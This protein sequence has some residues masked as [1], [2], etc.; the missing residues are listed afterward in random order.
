MDYISTTITTTN[1]VSNTG[2][3]TFTN[4]KASPPRIH[5]VK[6]PLPTKLQHVAPPRVH[7][8]K[9]KSPPLINIQNQFSVLP[10]LVYQHLIRT[11]HNS[12]KNSYLGC[13]GTFVKHMLTIT[14]AFHI[15]SKKIHKETLV[16]L[17]AGDNSVTWWTS[18]SKNLGRLANRVNGRV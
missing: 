14:C 4:S 17:L 13:K 6:C 12:D 11:Q 10:Q 7:T 16:T 18:V 9:K 5:L 2:S 3:P 1:Y 15:Y 8:P